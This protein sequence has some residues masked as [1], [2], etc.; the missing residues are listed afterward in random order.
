ML[1][2]ASKSVF[3]RPLDLIYFVYFA[4]H[5]PIALLIDFQVFYPPSWVP[6]PLR[7]VLHDFVVKYKDPFMGSE[8]TH[9]LVPKFYGH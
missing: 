9:L 2:Q 6:Q 4:T 8:T 3:T 5:I 7:N 1:Q